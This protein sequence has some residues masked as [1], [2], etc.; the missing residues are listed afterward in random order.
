MRAYV[1]D[2]DFDPVVGWTTDLPL[3]PLPGQSH[4]GVDLQLQALAAGDALLAQQQME[5]MQHQLLELGDL[6]S[7][8]HE[9]TA[10]EVA[11]DAAI[12]EQSGDYYYSHTGVND[13]FNVFISE[14]GEVFMNS[15]D[16]N[17]YTDTTTYGSGHY[18]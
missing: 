14:D 4:A 8:V 5:M 17:P 15:Y 16:Y 2:D 12:L 3:P 11:A 18:G 1:L 7:M 6:E 13:H 9:L 10:I